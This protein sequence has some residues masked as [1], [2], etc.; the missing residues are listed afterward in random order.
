[1]TA[2]DFCYWLHGYVNSAIRIEKADIIKKMS[3]IDDKKVVFIHSH[4]Q[5]YASTLA[6]DHL[7]IHFKE[8]IP[9]SYTTNGFVKDEHGCVALITGVNRL[10]DGIFIMIRPLALPVAFEIGKH[11]QVGTRLTPCL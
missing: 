2:Q 10:R 7:Y 9:Y 4:P 3:Y 11:F 8:P 1:M 5:I 6:G